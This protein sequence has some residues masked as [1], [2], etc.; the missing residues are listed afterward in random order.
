VRTPFIVA[1]I[2][3]LLS[4]FGTV[5]QKKPEHQVKIICPMLRLKILKQV[6]PEYPREAREAGIEGKV[7]LRCIIGIDGTVN[8]IEVTE[9]KE[10]FVQ[11]AKTAVAQWKFRPLVLNRVAVESDTTVDVIFELSKQPKGKQSKGSS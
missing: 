2:F 11:S 1:L 8:E 3:A 4:P 5:G 10:P 9:G 6:R 7:S